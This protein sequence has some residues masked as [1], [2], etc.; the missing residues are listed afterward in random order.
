MASECAEQDRY[1]HECASDSHQQWQVKEAASSRSAQPETG[2]GMH[3]KHGSLMESKTKFKCAHNTEHAPRFGK[4]QRFPVNMAQSGHC[5]PTCFQHYEPL[6]AGQE[7]HR[8]TQQTIGVGHKWVTERQVSD[9]HVNGSQLIGGQRPKRI[10]CE[11]AEKSIHMCELQRN[12]QP[13]RPQ[14]ASLKVREIHSSHTQTERDSCVHPTV[15]P[16]L[17]D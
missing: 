4:S 12:L 1:A 16:S 2:R 13:I 15:S 9:N 17:T 11:L 5:V 7:Q 3:P 8:A 14:P 10:L 6:V